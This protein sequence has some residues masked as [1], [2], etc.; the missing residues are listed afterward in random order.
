[1]VAQLEVD[2]FAAV[3]MH[4]QEF[5]QY[6]DGA[7]LNVVNDTMIGELRALLQL[8]L[9][10]PEYRPVFLHQ[11]PQYFGVP[12]S[13]TTGIPCVPGG[14]TTNMFQVTTELVPVPPPEGS[15][16]LNV[17]SALERSIWS[18]CLAMTFIL[19]HFTI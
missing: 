13:V 8:F 16:D 1:L 17:G 15:S 2:G 6:Q 9:Q 12:A 3:M 7:Y 18:F 14:V 4:P 11:I 19:L 10:H 5:S